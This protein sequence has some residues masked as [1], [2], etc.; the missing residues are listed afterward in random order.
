MKKLGTILLALVVLAVAGCATTGAAAT[1][2]PA[3]EPYSV[4]LR[5]CRV[6]NWV[7]AT[8]ALG[9]ATTGVRNVAPFGTRYD[10]VVV[11]FPALPDN[12]TEY[13]RVTITAKYFG[14]DGRTEITQGDGA[15]MVVMFYDVNGDLEGPEQ[16]AGRNT[17]LKEFNLGG[18]SGRVAT[19]QGTRI[20]LNQK[21]GGLLLQCSNDTVKFIELTSVIFHD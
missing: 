1:G 9:N 10:G 4:D 11:N 19:E 6:Q 18:F 21:P 14:A 8:K 17:P 7:R 3:K 12:I 20:I 2:G 5:Q 13:K 16:G 15:A